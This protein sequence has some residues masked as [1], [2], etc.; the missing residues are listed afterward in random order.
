MYLFLA[1][2]LKFSA[3]WSCYHVQASYNAIFIMLQAIYVLHPTLGLRTAV[4]A[5]QLFVDGEVFLGMHS[6]SLYSKI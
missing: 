4:F 3:D 1:R 5:L 6:S 2:V